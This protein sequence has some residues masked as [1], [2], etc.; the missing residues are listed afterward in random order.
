VSSITALKPDFD[1]KLMSTKYL[2]GPSAGETQQ[3]YL[4]RIIDTSGIDKVTRCHPVTTSEPIPIEWKR[5]IDWVRYEQ[6]L[7]KR[8]CKFRD[9]LWELVAD[10]LIVGK[11]DHGTRQ[12]IEEAIR[13]ETAVSGHLVD[14]LEVIDFV[15]MLKGF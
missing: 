5:R 15:T 11:R 13:L 10:L 8:C 9:G 3:E 1:R 4:M 12:K 6:E 2:L 7:R 14:E